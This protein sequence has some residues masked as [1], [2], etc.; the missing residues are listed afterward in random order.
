MLFDN[1]EAA[2][3]P[4]RSSSQAATLQTYKQKYRRQMPQHS[5]VAGGLELQLSKVLE[6][7]GIRIVT[8]PF[9]S[10][11]CKNKI[12]I[13]TVEIQFGEHLIL[14]FDKMH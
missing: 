7:I 14:L 8:V 4:P 1:G 3:G 5:N 12:Q 13:S 2:S 6:R 11:F 9:T 10:L